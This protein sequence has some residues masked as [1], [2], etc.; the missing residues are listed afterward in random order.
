MTVQTTPEGVTT[1]AEP[2]IDQTAGQTTAQNTEDILKRIEFLEKD[3]DAGIRSLARGRCRMV[4]KL[5]KI[6]MLHWI[7]V[8]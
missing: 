6:V 5:R 1:A 3:S 8:S 2:V 7:E 4:R